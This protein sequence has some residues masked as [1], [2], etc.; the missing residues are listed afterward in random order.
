M[1]QTAEMARRSFKHSFFTKV[2]AIACWNIWKVRNAF[3]FYHTRPHF[4]TW[5]AP[6]I[7]DIS[8]HAHRFE[9]DHKDELF[10]WL[11]SLV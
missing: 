8:L 6:F 1:V 9:S 2:V 3:I 10:K 5:R 7:R 11:A 4:A